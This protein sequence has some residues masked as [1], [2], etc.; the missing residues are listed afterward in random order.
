MALIRILLLGVSVLVGAAVTAE[1]APLTLLRQRRPVGIRRGGGQPVQRLLH[2]G[3]A[4]RRRVLR[5]HKRVGHTVPA[6]R[7]QLPFAAADDLFGPLPRSP[8]RRRWKRHR[9]WHR[10]VRGDSGSRTGEPDADRTR[11]GRFHRAC[12]RRPAAGL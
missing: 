9:A 10:Y 4:P 3:H 8:R 12:T 6:N 11:A 2:L 1:A 5:T 7:L